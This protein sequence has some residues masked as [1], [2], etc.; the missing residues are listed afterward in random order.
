MFNL[1][2]YNYRT[3]IHIDNNISNFHSHVRLDL[4]TYKVPQ[5]TYHNDLL[6]LFTLYPIPLPLLL[7]LLIDTEPTYSLSLTFSLLFVCYCLLFQ[8]SLLDPTMFG[9]V[10]KLGMSVWSHSFISHHRRFFPLYPSERCFCSKIP[11]LYLR[12]YKY[13]PLIPP[14]YVSVLAPLWLFS[15]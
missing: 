5:T 15:N 6:E 11:K 2:C 3:S 4:T 9:S 8:V 1:H 12:D 14:V 13:S 10:S 7:L